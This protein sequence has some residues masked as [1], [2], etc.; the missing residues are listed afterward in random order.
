MVNQSQEVHTQFLEIEPM[1]RAEAPARR[2]A[3]PLCTS[4]FPGFSS[5]SSHLLWIVWG[6]ERVTGQPLFPLGNVKA[7]LVKS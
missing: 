1:M 7:V 6:N 3:A 4:R 2:V 5:Q